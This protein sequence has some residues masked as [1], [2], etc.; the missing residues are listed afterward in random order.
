[1]PIDR[2][3]KGCLL[4]GTKRPLNLV[5]A[6]GPRSRMNA[7]LMGLLRRGMMGWAE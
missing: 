7:V 2:H 6:V 1:M 3:R 5:I 4:L